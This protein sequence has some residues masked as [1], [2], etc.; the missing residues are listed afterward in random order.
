MYDCIINPP[1][2][3][4]SCEYWSTQLQYAIGTLY[5]TPVT[6]FCTC[7]GIRLVRGFGKIRLVLVA[8]TCTIEYKYSEYCCIFHFNMKT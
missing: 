7:T 5:S 3:P 8:S 4:T 2:T 6:G 1:P